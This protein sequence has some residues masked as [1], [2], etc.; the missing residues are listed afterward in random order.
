[1]LANSYVDMNLS[2]DIIKPKNYI[3]LVWEIHNY[4]KKH[5]KQNSIFIH[6]LSYNIDTY[7]VD[8]IIDLL[9]QTGFIVNIY[10]HNNFLAL[11]VYSTNN[12]DV[13]NIQKTI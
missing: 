13:N 7:Y 5:T 2:L 3:K 8:M 4:F 11:Y 10:P 9:Y 1:M 6:E 12:I